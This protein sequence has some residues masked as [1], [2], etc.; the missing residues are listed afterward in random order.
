M[1]FKFVAKQQNIKIKIKT[2]YII[3]KMLYKLEAAVVLVTSYNIYT[4]ISMNQRD[5]QQL[6]KM[7]NSIT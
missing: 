7:F 6:C 5:T 3:N 2:V 1:A 4:Y